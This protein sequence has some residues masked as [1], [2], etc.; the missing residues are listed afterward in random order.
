M[1]NGE[2]TSVEHVPPRNLFP[3]FKD[4]KQNHRINLVTV[5]SCDL[6]NG[7]KSQDDEFL[8]VSIAGIIGNNSIGYEHYNGKI[9]R[10]IKRSSYKLLEKAFLKRHLFRIQDENK[11]LDILWGTPDY[12]RLINCFTHIAYGI[13]RHHFKTNFQGTTKPFLGF[14]H[15][16]DKNPKAFKAYIKHRAQIDLDGKIKYGENQ[17]VFYYQITDPDKFG[18]F[19]VYLCFYNNVDIYVSFQPNDGKPPFDLGIELMNSEI[20]TI[21]RVGDKEY[22]FN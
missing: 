15:T 14:L 4:A 5:P 2:A 16:T 13:H 12:A 1:C 19:L 7:Q 11:F 22:E 8:M 6:H 21:V 17:G 10:A 3:E 20:K 9:Q 18:I